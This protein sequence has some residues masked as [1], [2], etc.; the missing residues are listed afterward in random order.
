MRHRIEHYNWTNV[1]FFGLTPLLAIAGVSWRLMEGGPHWA[2]WLLTLFFVCACSLSVTAGYHR[3][4]THLSY[5][6][7]WPVR[8]FFVIF[9]SASFQGSILWWSAEHRVHHRL[10][11]TGKDPYGIN[12]GFWYAHIGWLLEK[13]EDASFGEVPD[14]TEDK[15][16]VLQDRYFT[17]LATFSSFVLPT[18]IASLWGDP[19]GGFLFAGVSRMVFNHHATFCINS[20]CHFIGKRTYSLVKTARDSW[21][22]ALI[23]FGEGYHSFHHAFQY[24]YRNAIR[25]YQWDPTKW[26]ISTLAFFGLASDLRQ[27]KRSHILAARIQTDEARFSARLIDLSD[28][29]KGR[30]L[31]LISG[32]KIRV[33]DAHVCWMELKLEYKEL[34]KA[35]LDSMSERLDQLKLEM[36][37]SRSE[38][39]RALLQWR[40][41]INQPLLIPEIA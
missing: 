25:S 4:Y 28:V 6:A 33:H 1:I 22:S 26:L 21:V 12:K 10:E 23:T 32:A 39:R 7:C 30:A 9:G 29:A 8:L 36:R 11:D 20:V 5:K 38:F 27:A 19:W 17:S 24:D 3:L 31:E 16:L 18:A 41:L 15:M 40:E 37:R 35:K 13:H 14:L 34:K 2:T